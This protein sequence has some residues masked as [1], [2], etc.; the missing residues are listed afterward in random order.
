MGSLAIFVDAGYV[1]AACAELLSG[2][3]HERRQYMLLDDNEFL[4]LLLSVATAR[5]P[6]YSLLRT[7]WYDAAPSPDQLSEQQLQIATR[8]DCK[9]RLGTLSRENVQ[10]GVDTLLVLDLVKLSQRKAISSAILVTG[11]D[12]I[13]GAVEL[14]QEHGVRVHLVGIEP[15]AWH[16]QAARL[17]RECD[18][19]TEITKSQVLTFFALLT[20][21]G[22]LR[23]EGAA[24]PPRPPLPPDGA[25]PDDVSKLDEAVAHALEAATADD[26]NSVIA[27]STGSFVDIPPH[28]Y[29]RLLGR[30]GANLGRELSEDEKREM[31]RRFFDQVNEIKVAG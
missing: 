21:E 8:S 10:K 30:Y 7:Y 22:A 31:R 2:R 3:R 24:D 11:D 15:R 17:Q 12:D 23:P 4:P 6:G 25:P 19:V 27:N 1:F 16:N 5:E 13:R 14:A 9:L 26:V 29:R 28:I 20:D 18:S